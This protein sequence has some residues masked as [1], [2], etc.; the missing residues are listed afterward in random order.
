MGFESRGERRDVQ[1]AQ[2]VRG[3]EDGSRLLR[4]DECERAT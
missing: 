3:H 1:F 4:G 2:R